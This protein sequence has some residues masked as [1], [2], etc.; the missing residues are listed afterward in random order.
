MSDSHPDPLR[1][2]R[3]VPEPTSSLDLTLD[4]PNTR[5]D[6]P[7]DRPPPP[8]TIPGYE[9]LAE[10]GRGGMGVVY[11][12]RQVAL[13]RE[14]ALKTILR[15][16][17]AD[18][19]VARFWAEAEVMAAVRHPHVVQ[20]FD[21]GGHDG[22]LFLA[23]ELV[24]GGSLAGRLAGGPLPPWA[25]AEKAEQVAR[26]VAAAHDLG[27]VHRDL[28]PGN[29]QL[30][31]AGQPKVTDF[32]L[33]KWRSADLTETNAVMGTPAY[34]APEQ[35]AGRTKYVGPS[36]DVW[37]LGVILYECVAGRRPFEGGTAEVLL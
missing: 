16:D 34:M 36:A 26:G 2:G 37:A 23:M 13:N 33:A 4:R 10:L 9:I 32:G 18:G 20:V 7:A 22:R 17:L 28:K 30:D 12:A 29:V 8:Q 11:H 35:A 14:V 1:A 19:A 6:P 21:L 3:H 27:V 5:G 24:A 15:A 25:A 31:P